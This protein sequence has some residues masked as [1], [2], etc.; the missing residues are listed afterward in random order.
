MTKKAVI[1]VSLVSESENVGDEQIKREIK[2]SLK[3]DWLAEDV[4]VVEKLMDIP[5]EDVT[6]NSYGKIEDEKEEVNGKLIT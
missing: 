4:S 3:C 5:M 2:E 6:K 1:V